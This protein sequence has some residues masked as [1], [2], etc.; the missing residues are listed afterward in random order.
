MELALILGL[1]ADLFGAKVKIVT[2][3]FAGFWAPASPSMQSFPVRLIDVQRIAE[4]NHFGKFQVI[5]FKHFPF[6]HREQPHH[7]AVPCRE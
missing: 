5:G 3:S 7:I 4:I 6:Y 1:V 2:A